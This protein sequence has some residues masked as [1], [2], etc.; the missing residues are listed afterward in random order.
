MADGHIVLAQDVPAATI[1]ADF[2]RVSRGET[3][4]LDRETWLMLESRRDQVVRFVDRD[5]G[6]AHPAYGFNRGFGH[7]VGLPVPAEKRDELQLNLIRSHSCGVA[8]PAPVEIVRGAMYL[9]ALSLARGHSGVRPQV[10][11]ALVN[12]LNAGITPLVPRLGTVSASGDLAPLSHIALALIGEGEVFYRGER[13]PAS[14]A[15]AEAGIDPLVLE[16]KEGLALNN[17]VQ[18]SNA[19]GLWCLEKMDV[20]LKSAAVATALTAQVMLGADTPFRSDLHSLR[21]HRG[22]RLVAGWLFELMAGSPLRE[23]HRSFDVDGEIQ[24]PYNLRCAPQILGACAELL[25]RARTTFA[26]EAAAVTDN[27]VILQAG[28]DFETACPDEKARAFDG[29]FVDIVSGGHFHGMPVAVDLYGL[30]QACGIMC[31]L[32][33]MRAVRYIDG[34]RNKELGSDLKPYGNLDYLDWAVHPDNYRDLPEDFRAHVDSLYPKKTA[35]ETEQAVS[36]TFMIPEYV[37]AGLTNW[38]WGSCMPVHLFSLSTDAGQE[39]HVSMAANVAIRLQESLPRVAEVIAIELA[40]GSQAAE[41]R[42]TMRCI[43]SRLKKWHPLT[44]AETSLNPVGEA[45]LNAVRERF[46]LVVEDRALG[47]DTSRLGE[48]VMEGRIVEAAEAAGFSFA[49]LASIH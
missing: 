8:D 46:P 18:Y 21:P 19:Y 10:V 17:G 13:R 38:I 40:L 41:L 7:N 44:E 48:A 12:L 6:R 23:S 32:S 33:N 25:E 24:D 37:S 20:L 39:D 45:V 14:A 28:R 43:P 22:S 2:A 3:V 34:K 30:L 49:E 4:V 36:S 35:M 26:I 31:R 11:E 42:K 15:L 29:A 47:S 27:P 1:L 9:R 5:P 16:M